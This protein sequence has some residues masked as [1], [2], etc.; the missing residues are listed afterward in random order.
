MTAISRPC[1][2]ALETPGL[3]NEDRFHL[4]FALGKALEDRGEARGQLRSLLPKATACAAPWSTTT[5]QTII[6]TSNDRSR[7]SPPS[8]SPSAKARAAPLPTRSS[9]SACRARARPWLSK[10]C[11]SHSAIEG[12]PELPD[13]PAIARRLDGRKVR[14]DS[15]HYPECLAEM[16]RDGATRARRGI[17]RTGAGPAHHRPS[18]SSSTNCRTIGRMSASSG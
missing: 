10:S 17:S 2:D 3:S 8:S 7:C 16:I 1:E 12:T 13:I 14:G 9:S 5:P 18:P 6:G 4:H 15:S 11:A